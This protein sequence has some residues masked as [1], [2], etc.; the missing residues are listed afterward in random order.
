M[1]P[2]ETT[3]VMPFGQT[4]AHAPTIPV[5]S[6]WLGSWQISVAR[7][8][9]SPPELAKRYDQA[10]TSWQDKIK[11]LGFETAY[12]YLLAKLLCQPRYAQSAR[13]LK[14]LDAGIG[15]GAMSCALHSAVEGALELRGVDISPA[16]LER[17]ERNLLNRG[18]TGRLQE[19]NLTAL[20]FQDDSFDMVMAAHV[21]EH[22]TDP[23]QALAEAYR[24]L[25]PGGIVVLCVTRQ[26]SL[27]AY[28]QLKWRTHRV[29]ITTALGWLRSAGFQSNRAVPFQRRSIARHLSIGYV[30]RKPS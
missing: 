16:M 15:T 3:R 27:G 28:I 1:T 8:P 20:P 22:L 14:V 6:G 19:A 29:A 18:I 26:S 17:A 5:F 11:H 21:L 2:L 12:R 30:G 25:K 7:R 10:A 9:L 13:P 24:V 23:G 4:L